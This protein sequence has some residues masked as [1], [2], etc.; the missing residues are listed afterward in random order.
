VVKLAVIGAGSV[1]CSV[2]VIA[3]LAS[4]F[5]ERRLDIRLYDADEERLD[6][7][8]RFA[9]VAFTTTD[10]TH[11][12]A[13]TSDP[14]EALSEA[15]RVILQLDANCAWKQLGRPGG[16]PPSGQPQI[17]DTIAESSGEILRDL[18]IGASVVSLLHEDVPI[19]LT[20]YYRLDWPGDISDNDRAALPHQ[21]LRWIKG[22]EYVFE[23]LKTY[24]RSPLKA[25]LDDATSA[26]PARG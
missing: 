18:E 8:D 19:P 15:E 21:V 3:S 22:D 1:R 13:A 26:R 9:R 7:F 10:A 4:Y 2:P 16:H 11:L 5:G 25:W 12:V 23:L 6:L 14:Q 24:E 17:R 20:S